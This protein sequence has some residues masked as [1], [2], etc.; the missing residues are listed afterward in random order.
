[1]GYFG[2]QYS[3]YKDSE[4]EEHN[5]S[6]NGERYVYYKRL[7]T[8]TKVWSVENKRYYSASEES[9]NLWR[10]LYQKSTSLLDYRLGVAGDLANI[11]EYFKNLRDSEYKKEIN[12][13]SKVLGADALKKYRLNEQNSE[14]IGKELIGAIN[15]LLNIKEVFKRNYLLI[16]KTDAKQIIG[17]FPSYFEREYDK[18]QKLIYADIEEAISSSSRNIK[19]RDIIDDVMNQWIEKLTTD[20][21]ITM[22]SESE[23]EA[24][25]LIPKE[26]KDAYREI[27]EVLKKEGSNEFIKAF[28]KIYKLTD[29]TDWIES[30]LGKLTRSN[31][32]SRVRYFSTKEVKNSK[33]E[34]VK[35]QWYQ[36]GGL[37]SEHLGNFIANYMSELFNNGGKSFHTGSTQ[38]KADFLVTYGVENPQEIIDKWK[39]ENTFGTRPRDI[40]A[41]K[42]LNDRLQD[43]DD[44]FLVY[45][46]AKNIKLGENSKR[47]SAGSAINMDTFDTMMHMTPGAQKVGRSLIFMAHQLIP[48]AIGEGDDEKVKNAFARTIASALFDDYETIGNVYSHG[49]NSVHLLY[50]NGIYLPIS[51][52]FNL[53]HKAF[54]EQSKKEIDDL[55]LVTLTYPKHI[56]YPEMKDQANV[57]K[58]WGQQSAE[59][60]ER[61]KIEYR[62]L[63]SFQEEMKKLK[64]FTK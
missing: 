41:I 42:D 33:G 56:K 59:A 40:Q 11:A 37:A 29:I 49:A 46:N 31:W 60:V 62:F 7:N 30:N 53:L 50:L 51:F 45:V 21:L 28:I 52:Y 61:T 44:S 5:P 64:I 32:K 34:Y 24:S 10:S 36:E 13:L 3:K 25:S 39:E 19:V 14:V 23:T 47:F 54:L 1:M 27:A 12:L 48:G 63:N 18:N 38:Q 55:I 15:G 8:D 35:K 58:P 22:F 16:T 4:G 2:I 17:S 26:L 43:I 57:V 9:I 6:I 20:A